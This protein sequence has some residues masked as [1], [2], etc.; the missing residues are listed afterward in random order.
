MFHRY[1]QHQ[2]TGKKVHESV[3]FCVPRFIKT[4]LKTISGREI[5]GRGM[6]EGRGKKGH[7]KVKDGLAGK[8]WELA[9]MT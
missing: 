4:P 7:G 9:P 8:L 6:G 2:F 1:S 3:E 5:V